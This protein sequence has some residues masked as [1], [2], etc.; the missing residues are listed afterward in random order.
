MNNEIVE[1]IQ[2]ALLFQKVRDYTRRRT[3]QNPTRD[4]WILVN[5]NDVTSDIIH[6]DPLGKSDHDVLA[7]ELAI[8]LAATPLASTYVYNLGKGNYEQMRHLL[9]ENNW[10]KLVDL[11]VKEAWINVKTT[12]LECMEQAIPKK[13]KTSITK[14]HP[15]WMTKNL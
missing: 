14:L 7:F 6:L 3:G 15:K 13:R 9:N 1:Y 10:S 4:D 8:P 12:I 11:D 2:D 5:D